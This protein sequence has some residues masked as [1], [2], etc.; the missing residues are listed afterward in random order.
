MR[1]PLIAGNWKMYTTLMDAVELA[2]EIRRLT[3]QLRDVEIAVFPP[4]PFLVPVAAKLAG[5]R[6]GL[7]AQDCYVAD[8]GA[9]TGAV[10]APMLRSVGCRYIL[11][12]HSERRSVFGDSDAT[13]AAKVRRTVDSGMTA[14]LCV[15]ETAQ[16]RR[17]GQTSVVV[18]SQ[19]KLGL[20]QVSAE[21]IRSNVVIAYEP[22]WAIGTGDTATPAMAQDVHAFIRETLAGLGTDTLASE[23]RI[24]YGGSVK[25]DN[26]DGLMSCPDID[27][28]LVGGASLEVKSF[29]R[30]AKFE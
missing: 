21:E 10:S 23:M 15:G 17:S 12:G 28:A 24:L 4:F 22:V 18:G 9:F 5:S 16:E 7:G 26:V 3:E 1:K 27:G 2:S 20:A 19:V 13:V 6:I 29:V 30:I 11:C 8:K 14:V 25:P